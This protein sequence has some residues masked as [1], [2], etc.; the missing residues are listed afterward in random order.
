MPTGM[1]SDRSEDIW[2][3][4]LAIADAAGG[5]WPELARA[6]C[7]YFAIDHKP[8]TET[9]GEKLLRD[10]LTVFTDDGRDRIPS[11]EL[12]RLLA[13][14]PESRWPHI[15]T[16]RL[17]ALLKDFKVES[18]RP[19][20][21]DRAVGYSITGSHGLQGAWDQLTTTEDTTSSTTIT[22]PKETTV[23]KPI[24]I[25]RR[26]PEPTPVPLAPPEVPEVP[27]APEASVS[28]LVPAPGSET[29]YGRV[30]TYSGPPQTPEAK[31]HR[32]LRMHAMFILGIPKRDIAGMGTPDLTEFISSWKVAGTAVGTGETP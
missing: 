29:P 24:K 6:A 11:V 22:E 7:R 3:P 5:R 14:L 32:D 30:P 31:K 25:K 19:T 23:K 9:D 18:D 27:E 1:P 2:R 4:L 12:P 15:T 21:G 8:D 20:S 10:L 17:A 26:R 28:F 13:E 16:T